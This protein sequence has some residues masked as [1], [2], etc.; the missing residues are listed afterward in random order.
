MISSYADPKPEEE[1]PVQATSLPP[2]LLTLPRELRD[3]ILLP[4]I[5]IDLDYPAPP[6]QPA[7]TFVS[8]HLR[9]E[10]L[11]AFYAVNTFRVQLDSQAK[12][13]LAK[14]W[15]RAVGDANVAFLRNVELCGWRRIPFGHMV[16]RVRLTAL[17]DLKHG[18]VTGEGLEKEELE[19][20]EGLVSGWESQ[21]WDA[22]RL[23]DVLETFEGLFMGY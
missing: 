23:G 10:T 19:Q 18:K 6:Q 15:L 12:L 8:K 9:Y 1:P 13:A 4:L 5:L 20:L 3:Q 17:V 16:R 2:T 21:G 22:N 7:I 11:P 14:A